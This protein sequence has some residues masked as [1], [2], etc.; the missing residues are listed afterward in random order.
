MQRYRGLIFDVEQITIERWDWSIYSQIGE[1]PLAT[2]SGKGARD[3]LKAARLA[4]DA[5][6]EKHGSPDAH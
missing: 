2:G 6:V 5:W 4:V 1:R 3:A